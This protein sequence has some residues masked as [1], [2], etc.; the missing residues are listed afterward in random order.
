M[1]RTFWTKFFPIFV[2]EN[3]FSKF[4]VELGA[5]PQKTV[6]E[7]GVWRHSIAQ[8][9]RM[10]VNV[11]PV[12]GACRAFVY[13]RS[14]P[15]R[16]TASRHSGRSG[17]FVT[18]RQRVRRNPHENGDL[19]FR[20]VRRL[21]DTR[22]RGH[23]AMAPRSSIRQAFAGDGGWRRPCPPEFPRRSGQT[24]LGDYPRSRV[25][26]PQD[27]KRERRR[28]VLGTAAAPIFNAPRHAASPD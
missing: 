27:G 16:H 17:I 26:F 6:A 25:L 28:R 19:V 11:S 7:Q 2:S 20:R 1:S 23:F 8:R 9:A 18:I 13:K 4:H 24:R 21:P 12:V 5:G 22:F 10:F 15:R 14:P 3:N